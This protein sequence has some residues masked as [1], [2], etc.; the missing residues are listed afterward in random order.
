[1]G[2]ISDIFYKIWRFYYDGFRQMTIGKSLWVLILV[3]LFLIFIV[4]KLIFF[5]DILKRDYSDDTQRAD[6]VREHLS[7]PSN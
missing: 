3:K 2:N 5:P 1:M 4:M 7:R 6:A